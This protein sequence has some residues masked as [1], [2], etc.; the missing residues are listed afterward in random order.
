MGQVPLTNYFLIIGNGRI[1]RHF[2]NYFSNEEIPYMVWTR[3][4]GANE[5]NIQAQRATHVL[6]LIPD[7]AIEGFL[8]EHHFLANNRVLVHFSGSLL[9][10]LAQG[11]HPLMTFADRLYALKVYKEM[12]FVV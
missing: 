3:T 5:L 11:A 1:A 12:P 8:R 10:P 2:Q 7:G 9:T 6:V 4:L